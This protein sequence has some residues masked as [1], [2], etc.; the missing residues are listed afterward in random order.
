MFLVHFACLLGLKLKNQ[1][2]EIFDRRY[3][4]RIILQDIAHK[5][6]PVTLMA[7]LAILTPIASFP[8]VSKTSLVTSF[9]RFISIADKPA[10]NLPWVSTDVGGNLPLVSI[11]PMVH[12]DK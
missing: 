6:H 2:H 12:N 9:I 3:L 7:S 8:P 1:C 5:V 11:K 4:S 10:V